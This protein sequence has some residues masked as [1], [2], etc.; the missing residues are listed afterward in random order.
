MELIKIENDVALL[1]AGVSAKIAD[2]ERQ[3]KA[4]KDQEDN[5]KKAILE[6]MEE[7]GII[8]IETDDLLISYVAST[9]REKFNTRKFRLINPD[10][11]DEYVSM[12][13]VKSSIRIK[14][15]G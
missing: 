3:M 9:D 10:I 2:F 8:N 13:P 7:K 11:Y 12:I 4:L 1:D 15:K 6:E 14:L 5:L